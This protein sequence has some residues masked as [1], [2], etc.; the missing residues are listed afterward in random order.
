[1]KGFFNLCV[2]LYKHALEGNWEE[3]KVIIAKDD[4]L[5]YAVVASGLSTVLHIAA[6]AGEDARHT[7]FGN[8]AFCFAAATGNMAVVNLMLE[9]DSELAEI[10]GGL[11]AAPVQLAA[12]QGR[13][14][15]TLFLYNMTK[16]VLREDDFFFLKGKLNT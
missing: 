7:H 15:M 8:T 9:M 3:A 13:C 2:P 12:L 4:R 1:M 10:R 5:K 11:G 16:R 6:G 14:V